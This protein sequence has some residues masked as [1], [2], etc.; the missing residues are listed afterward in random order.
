MASMESKRGTAC[1]FQS[2]RLDQQNSQSRRF[3]IAL[4]RSPARRRRAITLA[5][6]FADVGQMGE[7]RNRNCIGS[8]NRLR[9]KRPL[10]DIALRAGSVVRLGVLKRCRKI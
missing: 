2:Q 1:R 3:W 9:Q 6:R 7:V 5:R 4:R 8:F 10:D